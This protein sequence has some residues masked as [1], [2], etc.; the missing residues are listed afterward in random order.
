MSR[1]SIGT[2]VHASPTSSAKRTTSKKNKI[3]LDTNPSR[4]VQV[5][6]IELVEYE[7]YEVFPTYLVETDLARFSVKDKSIVY[8]NSSVRRVFPCF[9]S[10]Q[11]K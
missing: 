8:S 1:P 2:L 7:A 3:K 11:E 9:N 6:V 5:V 10:S 4:P